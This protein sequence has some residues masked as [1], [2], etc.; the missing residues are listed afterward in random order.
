[1]L[2]ILVVTPITVR[3]PITLKNKS[4]TVRGRIQTSDGSIGTDTDTDTD[5]STIIITPTPST[6]TSTVGIVVVV[7]RRRRSTI[8]I[9][10]TGPHPHQH[11]HLQP[12]TNQTLVNSKIVGVPTRFYRT[13]GALCCSDYF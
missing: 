9:T 1:V 4:N 7:D 13:K 6:S 11:Q 5:T 12:T 3:V 2:I 10:I 8:T